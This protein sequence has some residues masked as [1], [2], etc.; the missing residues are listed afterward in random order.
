M[1]R[2]NNFAKRLQE[3]LF[4]PE[5]TCKKPS[6]PAKDPLREKIIDL[7]KQLRKAETPDSKEAILVALTN[8]EEFPKDLIWKIINDLTISSYGTQ[9]KDYLEDL[10]WRLNDL[11]AG[12]F[13]VRH[14]CFYRHDAHLVLG[15]FSVEALNGVAEGL[16]HLNS[17]RHD[18][19]RDRAQYL[20]PLLTCLGP[21]VI[22]IMQS[23]LH[24]QRAGLSE[25]AGKIIDNIRIL[26]HSNGIELVNCFLE[27]EIFQSP[28][29]VAIIA[30]FN[31]EAMRYLI[32]N[33][34]RIRGEYC[35]R[36]QNPVESLRLRLVEA[37][38]K[39]LPFLREAARSEING[40]AKE[41]MYILRKIETYRTSA[42]L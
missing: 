4:P 29:S 27:N 6:V 14:R 35:Y 42:P 5:E 31:D 20:A 13:F 11:G 25:E 8:F 40:L 41:A 2:T 3:A 28:D 34:D 17:T 10:V 15:S 21:R 26:W 30:R 18:S 39:T 16:S 33:I 9:N 37:G 7:L 38:D 32:Q 36:T 23:C 1:I 19:P 22:P 12:R 24:S